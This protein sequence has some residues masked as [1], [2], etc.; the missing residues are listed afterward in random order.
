MKYTSENMNY[1][2]NVSYFDKIDWSVFGNSK[3]SK[4]NAE[5]LKQHNDAIREFSFKTV[6]PVENWRSVQ[7]KGYTDFQLYTD[8]PGLMIGIG[9]EHS[10]K[11]DGAIKC[12]F[13]FD[14]TTG[15]P[16]IPGASLKGALRACFPGDGKKEEASIEYALYI[17]ALLNK[18]NVDTDQLKKNIFENND[19]FLGAFP[20]IGVAGKKLLEMEFITPHTSGK[21]KNPNPISLVKV[22]PDVKFDFCFIL[23]DYCLEDGSIIVSAEEKKRLFKKLILDMGIGAKTHVGFGRFSEKRPIQLQEI[24]VK[25]QN[26]MNNRYNQMNRSQ[27]QYNRRMR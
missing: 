12:G 5:V 17:R 19:I 18:D 6:S 20:V 26:H 22:K 3:G 10:L 11:M 27:N 14:Y 2:F 8:Y 23:S 21:F 9:N 16:Y 15:L 13:S 1:I 25:Q 24:V 4:E 7:M